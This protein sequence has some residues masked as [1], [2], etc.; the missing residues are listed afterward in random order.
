MTVWMDHVNAALKKLKEK[1]PNAS[2]KDAFPIASASY[3]KGTRSHKKSVHKSHK[4]PKKHRKGRKS[5]KRR[6]RHSR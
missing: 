6:A 2:L 5:R 3:H 4:H 1:K